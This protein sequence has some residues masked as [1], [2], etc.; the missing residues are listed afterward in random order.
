MSRIAFKI[1]LSILF[2]SV[3]PGSG[4]HVYSDLALLYS[5]PRFVHNESMVTAF[6]FLSIFFYFCLVIGVDNSNCLSF[7]QIAR[8]S[9]NCRS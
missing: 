6:C 2:Y 1:I 5:K 4:V 7:I 8:A 3:A 9:I